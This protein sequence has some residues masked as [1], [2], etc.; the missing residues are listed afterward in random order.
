M[1]PKDKNDEQ[2][3]NFVVIYIHEPKQMS[4]TKDN[5]LSKSTHLILVQNLN[6]ME[7]S[8]PTVGC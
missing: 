6:V 2:E 1:S 7:T 8:L 3:P 5:K 4:E